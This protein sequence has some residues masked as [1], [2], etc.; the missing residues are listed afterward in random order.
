MHVVRRF[1]TFSGLGVLA[2]ALDI[3]LLAFLTE[4]L[5]LFYMV[6]ATLAF[7]FATSLHYS[8]ARTFAFPETKRSFREGYLFFITIAC[9]N[10]IV[11]L[12][13]FNLLVEK[14]G[15]YY[16][17]ARVLVSAAVGV[18]NFATNSVLNFNIPLTRG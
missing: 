5:G 6:S 7:L 4:V 17:L 13:L 10:L 8:A 15:I 9:I 2:F 18:S 1:V 3:A 16:L 14:L 12:V 11:T